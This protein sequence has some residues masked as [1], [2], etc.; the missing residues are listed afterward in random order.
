VSE[1]LG[2]KRLCLLLFILLTSIVMAEPEPIEDYIARSWQFLERNLQDLPA[3]AADPKLGERERYPVYLAPTESL[4]EVERRLKDELSAEQLSKVELR[5]LPEDV[6][7]HPQLRGGMDHQG[8]LYLP[9]PYVVPGGR[10]NEMY[11]WDSYFINLG[12]LESDRVEQAREMVE[13]HLYQVR[14]YGRVLNANRSYYLTRSQ[15]PFLASMVSDVYSRTGDEE[16]VRRALPALVSTYRFWT[17]APHLTPETGLSRYYD[18]GEG[19]APEVVASE[20]DESGLTHYDRIKADFREFTAMSEQEQMEGLGY[21]LDLYYDAESDE[22]TPLFYKGD[23]SMRESGYDPSDRFGRFNI[24]V[25]HYN[26]VDL[27]SLL[28]LYELEMGGL[29]TKLGRPRQASDWFAL[30]RERELNM[31]AYLWDEESGLFGDYNFRTGERRN[32]PFATT[33]FPLWTGWARSE[34]AAAVYANGELFVTPGGVVTSTHRSGN[35]WDSPFGWAP[36]QM[37]AVE[38]LARYGYHRQANHIAQ[39]F[40]S[41]VRQEYRKS[42]TVVEKYDV[43]NR[44]S[45]V[46]SGIEY[47]YSSNEIG[48]GWTNAV[49]LRLKR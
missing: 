4:V 24:D 6:V 30:A 13:N 29:F 48:F 19:P 25:I 2:M 36:L 27:N 14:H 49:Y 18:L 22:L 26:P 37:V 44:T 39:A 16:W 23:R 41:L 12:L 32:Y 28:Y 45:N 20:K 47:G 1:A 38:G 10:F 5:M 21:P 34:Q 42:G 31:Q 11:G 7:K 43:V 17:S 9:H 40:L 8:L 15:P 46:S 3:A 33:Y 35:Q